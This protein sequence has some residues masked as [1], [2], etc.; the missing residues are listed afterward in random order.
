MGWR[1]DSRDAPPSIS[2]LGVLFKQTTGMQ[3]IIGNHQAGRHKYTVSMEADYR[4]MDSGIAIATNGGKQLFDTTPDHFAAAGYDYVPVAEAPEELLA[5]L[6][7]KGRAMSVKKKY[8]NRPVAYLMGGLTGSVHFAGVG[9]VKYGA[10]RTA[11][12][13]RVTASNDRLLIPL[14]LFA[15]ECEKFARGVLRQEC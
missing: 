8:R 3:Q 12:I 5:A 9:V 11:Q 6:T 15:H 4:H 10:E 1:L 2:G 14:A 7:Q 13:T